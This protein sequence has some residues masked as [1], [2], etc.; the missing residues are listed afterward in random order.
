MP[1]APNMP[2]IVAAIQMTSVDDVQANLTSAGNLL[3]RAAAGGAQ[4]A[5]LPENFSFMGAHERAKLE[6]AEDDGTGPI[7]AFLAETAAR[8]SIAIVAGTV[9]LR[10]PGDSEHVFAASLVYDR[11]GAR[12]ARYDK[13][14]LFDVDVAEGAQAATRYRESATI[15]RGLPQAAAAELPM[16]R[17]GLSV[18]YDLRFPE[19]YRGLA[20]LGSRL[21]TV[22]SAFTEKTG[23]AHWSVLLRARAIENQFFVI[24]PNQSGS[25]PG[26]RRTW[27]HSMIV[28]P[29]GA[30]LAESAVEGP[31]VVL[32]EVDPGR[33]DALRASFPVMSHRRLS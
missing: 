3:A 17:V 11:H 19:L 10:V 1:E 16:G 24:A 20:A 13:I 5:V 29:W 18:C 14:H 21:V 30:I 22:P 6:L 26:S 33:I 2:V 32:A 8:L 12:V 31:D 15:A 7:Q 28:D 23:E 4:L 27:G 9:P 25:H